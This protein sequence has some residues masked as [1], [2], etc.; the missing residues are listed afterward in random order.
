[1]KK[2]KA[3][4]VV[5]FRAGDDWIGKTIA[6]LTDSDVSHA[7]I[8]LGDTTIAEMGMSGIRAGEVEVRDGHSARVLRM[9]PEKDMAP[10]LAA[11]E[12]YVNCKTRYD[13]PA[14]AILAGLIIYR[15]IRPTP[16]LIAITD[17]I[18]QSACVALDA[19]IQQL[20]LKN[21]D[22]A[23]VCSQLVYQVYDDC[24]KEYRLH[25]ENGLLQSSADGAVPD[26]AICLA[27]LA[28]DSRGL[29]LAVAGD[30]V[31]PDPEELSKELYLALE[32][33]ETDTVSCLDAAGLGMLPAWT[34]QFLDRLEEF[35]EKSGS[36]LPINALFITPADL[37]YK[38]TNLKQVDEIDLVRR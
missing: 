9:N 24:G 4:D 33:Q 31:F 10:V 8:M 17:L 38:T 27:E 19:L 7:A 34:G 14:L 29:D 28:A 25:V 23:L 35:L 15:R 20:V 22:K 18:L 21:P 32:E 6:W 12:V 30:A 5:V 11:A 1:M 3:G 16:R 2:L 37:A 26:G 13:F 36:N